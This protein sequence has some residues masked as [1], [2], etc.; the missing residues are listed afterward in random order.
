[1]YLRPNFYVE[2][3]KKVR[4]IIAGVITTYT[5]GE[6]DYTKAEFNA[7]VKI[8]QSVNPAF[9]PDEEFAKDTCYR[10]IPPIDNGMFTIARKL[11]LESKR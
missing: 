10:H 5:N 9:D 8:Y 3:E 2:N 6:I 1:M 11:I 7:R 4:D